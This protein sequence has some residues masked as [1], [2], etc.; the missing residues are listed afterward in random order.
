MAEKERKIR[1]DLTGR[2]DVKPEEIIRGL[3]PKEE[4][5]TQ[6]VERMK[7]KWERLQDKKND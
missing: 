7:S 2:H 3:M 1:T 5:K 4:P 6:V